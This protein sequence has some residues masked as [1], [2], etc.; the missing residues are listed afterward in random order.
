MDDFR[1]YSL[2]LDKEDRQLLSI[3]QNPIFDL[4]GHYLNSVTLSSIS[5]CS[6]D[7]VISFFSRGED[8][9]YHFEC[10]RL[11]VKL[12]RRPKK[13]T[14]T[15]AWS[16]GENRVFIM[17]RNEVLIKEKE[18]SPLTYGDHV[19]TQFVLKN[20]ET[21]NSILALCEV[22][23]G[24]CVIN[25]DGKKLLIFTDT[26]PGQMKVETDPERVQEILQYYSLLSL[27]ES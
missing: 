15:N 7:R 8:L 4:K 27:C 10:F 14:E 22:M 11:A 6:E 13:T 18:P 25:P 5:V 16:N 12:D 3:L 23:A 26:F 21:I 24:V 19:I 2:S 20:D 17:Q 1:R 9:E